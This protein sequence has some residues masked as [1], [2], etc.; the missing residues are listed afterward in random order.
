MESTNEE[1][2]AFIFALYADYRAGSPTKSLTMLE[3]L[4]KL[5]GENNWI[6][7]LGCWTQREDPQVLALTA[8][9]FNLQSQLAQLKG[10][11]GSIQAL[12]A[13]STVPNPTETKLQKP[14]PRK[15]GEPEIIEYK[16]F[17]WMWCDKC[18]NGTWNRTHVT[19]EHVAGVGKR[20]RHRQPPLD[21]ATKNTPAAAPQANLA[22]ASP[23]LP[24]DDSPPPP[25]QANMATSSATLDFI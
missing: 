16:G 25:A 21:D 1:F 13:K 22:Q 18:F 17:T 5:D 20:N 24:I 12:I 19:S 7:N 4:D 14:P 8:T 11:Y 15:S 2:R 9:I 6:N 23:P 3:L 10:Q